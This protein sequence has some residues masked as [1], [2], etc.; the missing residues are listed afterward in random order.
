V[1]SIMQSFILSFQSSP[2]IVLFEQTVM[3][4]I[5]DASGEQKSGKAICISI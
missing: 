3:M 4:E 2:G 1:K 5:E